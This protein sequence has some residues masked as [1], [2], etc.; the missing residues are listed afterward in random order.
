MKLSIAIDISPP[1][2]YL[3]KFWFSSYGSKCCW[4]IELQDSLKCN[5]RKKWM[6]KFIF[7][8]SRNI[9]IFYRLILPCNVNAMSPEEHGGIKWFFYLHINTKVFYKM[10]L[11]FWV[12]ATRPPQ[13]TQNNKFAIS[14]QNPKENRK[15]EVDFL[16]ADKHQRF[17]Q[18]DTIVLGVCGH[19]CPSYSK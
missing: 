2:T 1:I 11:S 5:L 6:M 7:A 3:E 13:S 4:P 19:A 8:M 17:L 15:N 10:I 12:F 9:E 16:L 18:I 14:F